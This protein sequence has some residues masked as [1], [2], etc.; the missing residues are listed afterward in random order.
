MTARLREISGLALVA[1]GV[2]GCLLPIIPGIPLIVAGAAILGTDH[3]LVRRSRAW[4][5]Q[6]GFLK[7]QA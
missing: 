4:L 1:V 7:P 6:K 3:A 5:E 2:A